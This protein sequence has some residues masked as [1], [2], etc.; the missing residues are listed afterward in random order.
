MNPK[1]SFTIRKQWIVDCDCGKRVTVPEYY[2][3][4]KPNPKVNC[5]QC[6]DLKTNKTLYNQEYRIWLMMLVR[7]TDPRHISYKYYGARGIKVCEEWSDPETGFDEFL[8]HIGSRPSENYT[9]DRYPDPDGN[10]QPGNV[11]WATGAQQAANKS[12]LGKGQMVPQSQ[13]PTS[14]P[15]SLSQPSAGQPGTE[16]GMEIPNVPLTSDGEP[17]KQTP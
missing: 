14:I 12:K 2:L 7:T 10:Y 3:E 4:R 16:N 5:G 11:R 17:P 15:Q 8:K 6:A 1:I 13:P 9:V